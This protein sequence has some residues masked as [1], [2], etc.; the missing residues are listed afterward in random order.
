MT[1]QAHKLDLEV[2]SHHLRLFGLARAG[3]ASMLALHLRPDPSALPVIDKAAPEASLTVCF[4]PSLEFCRRLG[5][6]VETIALQPP[7]V[8]DFT[9]ALTKP[10]RR[11]RTLH[12]AIAYRTSI[13]EPIVVW[14]G[15]P[16]WLFLPRGPG[17]LLLVGTNLA[18]DLVR[19]R[20][21]DPG[22]AQKRPDKMLWGIPGERPNY[23]F[24]GQLDGESPHER[25]ADWWAMALAQ[26]IAVKL[27]TSLE[28]ILPRGAAGAVVLTG[29]DDQAHLEKY[30]EQLALIGETP[31][32]Y[33]LH[34]LTRH[35]AK[36]LRGLGRRV[37]LG[38]HPDA[39]DA[40]M[41]YG[42]RFAENAE[43]F[44]RLTGKRA[45]SVRNH[46]YLND[47]YWGHL[48][49]WCNGGVRISSNLPGVD[50]R[51]LNGSLLPARIAYDG[52]LTEHWS[53]LTAIGDG[54]RFALGMSERQAADCVRSLGERIKGSGLPGVVVLNLHPQNVT[55]ARSM[56]DAALELMR[57]GFLAWNLRDCLAWFEQ[58]DGGDAPAQAPP[59]LFARLLL[60]IQA[61]R[62]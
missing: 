25:H 27:G 22:C 35:T 28:P 13:G 58:R 51:A 26:T 61:S 3:D 9:T 43:W 57:G 34:P 36:T 49:A 8:F 20:Q 16:V 59:G 39:L 1:S 40:P 44:Q 31:I 41:Q 55:V 33:F 7:L 12:P 4:Q 18:G 6:E 52:R 2:I 24:D 38:L 48:H 21:G 53:I 47:G 46:G 29:D 10:W 5:I 60:R 30:A 56:H 50:G 37:D 45:L 11:L 23:L 15:K 54:V 14:N 17:G 62:A 19:Y 32:T 42:E